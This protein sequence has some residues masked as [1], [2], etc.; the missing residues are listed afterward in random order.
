MGKMMVQQQEGEVMTSTQ[1]N[2]SEV[3]KAGGRLGEA[4]VS[5]IHGANVGLLYSVL[6]IDWLFDL[7]GGKRADGKKEETTSL[8]NMVKKGWAETMHKGRR[9]LDLSWRFGEYDASRAKGKSKSAWLTLHTSPLLDGEGKRSY[10]GKE[11]IRQSGQND[12][13]RLVAGE[14][15]ND[16][17]LKLVEIDNLGRLGRGL[18]V[19]ACAVPI[20]PEML[21]AFAFFWAAYALAIVYGLTAH[22]K[23]GSYALLSV[24]GFLHLPFV[25]VLWFPLVLLAFL[26]VVLFQSLRSRAYLATDARRVF[27]WLAGKESGSSVLPSHFSSAKND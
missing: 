3:E 21:I 26:G 9:F 2:N 24:L 15:E 11:R 27:G 5:A 18:L 12:R 20:L 8:A 10:K 14:V 25:W 13:E 1:Q 7:K 17:V 16:E 19:G 23:S 6:T 22:R 4:V